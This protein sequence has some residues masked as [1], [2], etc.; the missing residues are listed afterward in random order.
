MLKIIYVPNSTPSLTVHEHTWEVTCHIM[1]VRDHVTTWCMYNINIKM[2]SCD[3]VTVLYSEYTPCSINKSFW[4]KCTHITWTFT[5]THTCTCTC[6]HHAC[7]HAYK[8]TYRYCTC[9]Y[10][11]F[12]QTHTCLYMT[13]TCCVMIF[14]CLTKYFTLYKLQHVGMKS[15][16]KHE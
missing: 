10:S 4:I 13:H 2:G 15:V 8:N 9:M 1:C 14:S 11:V 5:C 6:I 16:R 3:D 12:I 7:V